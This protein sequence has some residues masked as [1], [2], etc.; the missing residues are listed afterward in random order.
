[1]SSHILGM[2]VQAGWDRYECS[3]WRV[4]LKAKIRRI[5][6]WCWR[7]KKIGTDSWGNYLFGHLFGEIWMIVAHLPRNIDLRLRLPKFYHDAGNEKI[8]YHKSCMQCKYELF[9]KSQVKN[10]LNYIVRPTL[11]CWLNAL[12][13]RCRHSLMGT[14]EE[15][16]RI[17]ALW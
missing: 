1:M 5:T 4:Q 16:L 14:R 12:I 3:T 7:I 9:W 17:F 8:W 15:C 13:R 11:F 6:L 2:C 10:A